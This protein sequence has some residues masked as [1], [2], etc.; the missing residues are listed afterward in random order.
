MKYT[1]TPANEDFRYYVLSLRTQFFRAQAGDLSQCLTRYTLRNEIT[2][3]D[4]SVS[5]AIEYL[6]A[7]RRQFVSKGNSSV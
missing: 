3:G 5:K 6:L 4:R 1:D 7:E 2:S